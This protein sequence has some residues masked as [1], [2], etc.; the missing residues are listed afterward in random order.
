MQS[1]EYM[2]TLPSGPGEQITIRSHDNKNDALSGILTRVAPRE[3]PSTLS[4]IV[5]D[6]LAD[7]KMVLSEVWFE[8]SDGYI[9]SEP[10]KLAHTHSTVKGRT[11]KKA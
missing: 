4:A 10:T 5:F 9:L 1:G 6:K 8:G 7:G 11:S 3:N 2:V